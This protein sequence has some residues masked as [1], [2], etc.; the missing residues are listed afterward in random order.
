MLLVRSG[1]AIEQ[2]TDAVPL[3]E[4]LSFAHAHSGELRLMARSVH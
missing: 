3:R 2:A 4:P 1:D